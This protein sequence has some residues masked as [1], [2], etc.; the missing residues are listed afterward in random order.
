M[1]L[2]EIL[3]LNGYKNIEQKKLVPKIYLM[4]DK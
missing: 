1:V 2:R 3:F 4:Q